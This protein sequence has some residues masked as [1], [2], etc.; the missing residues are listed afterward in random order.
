[1][2]ARGPLLGGRGEEA[3]ERDAHGREGPSGL[4]Q[5]LRQEKSPAAQERRAHRVRS[6]GSSRSWSGRR[7]HG[8]GRSSSSTRPDAPQGTSGTA[9]GC[10]PFSPTPSASSAGAK[11]PGPSSWSG[12]VEPCGP[13]R[14]RHASPHT[15]ATTH[16]IGPPTITACSPPSL[17]VFEDE[18]AQTHFLRV[19]REE[20]ARTGVTVPLRS[21]TGACW[22]GWGRWDGPGGKWTARNPASLLRGAE[23]SNWNRVWSPFR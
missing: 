3:V 21:P 20:M 17:V 23:Y 8:P 5:R 10:A 7:T 11:A 16:R 22:R 18:I 2:L 19:A 14:W 12:S 4:A 9:T 6:T 1:M 15:C 13:L